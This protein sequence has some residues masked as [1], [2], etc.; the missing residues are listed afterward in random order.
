M[1]IEELIKQGG[2]P[3]ELVE[4]DTEIHISA[5]EMEAALISKTKPKKKITGGTTTRARKNLD[6]EKA[7][8]FIR[9]QSIG[10]RREY[11]EWHE[12]NKPKLLPKYPHRAYS[13]EWTDWNDFLGNNN[14][15]ITEQDPNDR[16]KQYKRQYRPYEEVT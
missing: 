15:P 9:T 3:K 12:L 10:S 5:T 6:F 11:H 4:V 7:R 14:A 13:K 2:L 16:T 1:N 8:T